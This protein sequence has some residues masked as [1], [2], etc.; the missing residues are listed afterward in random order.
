MDVVAANGAP[1]STIASPALPAHAIQ[2][3]MPAFICSGVALAIWS[4]PRSKTC[5]KP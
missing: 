5:T 2:A 4:G 1:R 3:S